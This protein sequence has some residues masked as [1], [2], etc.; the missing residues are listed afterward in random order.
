MTQLIREAHFNPFLLRA[1]DVIIDLQY[2]TVIDCYL[3]LE[4][5][6]NGSTD[7]YVFDI[8]PHVTVPYGA[9]EHLIDDEETLTF[10]YYKNGTFTTAHFMV[11]Q[12][13]SALTS[14]RVTSWWNRTPP[15]A[16]PRAIEC[17]TRYA[18]KMRARQPVT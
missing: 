16:G 18:G 3:A 17:C 15:F 5:T 13:A 8:P 14:S 6:V 4:F 7:D 10:E 1:E 12:N 11:I 2:V 9:V